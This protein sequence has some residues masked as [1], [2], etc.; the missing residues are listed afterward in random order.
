M[1]P[2]DQFGTKKT[3]LKLGL[4]ADYYAVVCPTIARHYIKRASELHSLAGWKEKPTMK[5]CPN[6]ATVWRC[7][8]V[9]IA[10]KPRI[11]VNQRLKKLLE[12]SER[13]KPLS[14][15][16]SKYVSLYKEGMN[17]MVYECLVCSKKSIQKVVGRPKKSK[18]VKPGEKKL[19]PSNPTKNGTKKMKI[20]NTLD[21]KVTNTKKKQA[22][23]KRSLLE[24]LMNDRYNFQQLIIN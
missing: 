10:F 20:D 7:D 19:E 12:R 21:K 3:M 16:Q 8:N 5:F 2:D 4:A 1:D 18:Q 11:K 13:N 22:P 9:K 24:C 17:R 23:K 14:K 6:C 15:L